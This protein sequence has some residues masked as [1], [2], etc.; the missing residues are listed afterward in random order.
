MKKIA[1]W[2]G[3]GLGGFI[4]AVLLAAL[5][6]FLVGGTNSSR[7]YDLAPDGL[8]IPTD[9][10]SVARG[11]HIIEAITP[12][13]EC[14]GEGLSG[15]VMVDESGIATIYASNLTSGLGGVGSRYEDEDW[16]RAIRHGVDETGEGMWLMPSEYWNFIGDDDLVAMVAYIKS[17]P[18]VDNTVPDRSLGPVGKILVAVGLF[19]ELIPAQTIEHNASR[20]A[21]PA[22][23]PT[24]EYGR[25]LV[26]IA[27]CSVCHGDDYGGDTTPDGIAAPNIS[28]SGTAGT[29]TTAQFMQTLRT[30]ETPGGA[31]LNG[32]EMPWGIYGNM[33]DEE[34][35]AVFLYLNT[36]SA[37]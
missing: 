30:G 31:S 17:L 5:S 8:T 29:W 22:S 6:L 33:T 13:T 21:T 2:F 19:G 10:A 34:L 1:K 26:A 7:S 12:C 32:E 37:Q 20:A 24:V 3:I 36:Q 27:G 15:D 11:Q 14:H 35:T 9:A 25:Y 4:V 23:G 28:S 16:V 18:P